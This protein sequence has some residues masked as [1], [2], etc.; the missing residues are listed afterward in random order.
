MEESIK[1]MK[2]R[3][4]VNI[5]NITFL[6]ARK[7]VEFSMKV[8]NYSH[9]VQKVIPKRNNDGLDEGKRLMRTPYIQKDH[10]N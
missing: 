5:E 6:K 1:Y 8:N 10:S 2:V 3:E 4:K 9:I 7:I